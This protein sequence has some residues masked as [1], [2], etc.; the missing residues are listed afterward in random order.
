MKQ[1]FEMLIIFVLD[2]GALWLGVEFEIEATEDDDQVVEFCGG[3]WGGLGN[4]ET[5]RFDMWIASQFF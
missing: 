1:L 2:S 3:S 4:N 5:E